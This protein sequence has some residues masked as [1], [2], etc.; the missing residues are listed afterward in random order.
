[1]DGVVWNGFLAL[2]PVVLAY[3][4]V[5]LARTARGSAGRKAL[6]V[7]LSLGWL[8]F[9]PNTCYLLTEWRHFLEYVDSRDLFLRSQ[10]NSFVFVRLCGL[11]L[12]YFLYSGSGMFTFA[13]AIRPIEHLAA[14]RGASTWFW[15]IPFFIALSLGVYLGLVLRFNSWDLATRPGVVW[16]EIVAIGSRPALGSFIVLFGVFLW[17]A[18]KAIDIWI[19]GL[20][21]RLSRI[22]GRSIHVG[23]RT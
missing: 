18:Y 7:G 6:I 4:I 15:A 1:M 23:P 3:G 17:I 9:L 5:W 22:T 13:L 11:W 12:F 2:I 21:D 14:K 20:A 16:D 10:M 19:D 8:A